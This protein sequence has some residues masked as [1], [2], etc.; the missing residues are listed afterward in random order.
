MRTKADIAWAVSIAII[1]SVVFSG[2]TIMAV[3]WQ[4]TIGDFAAECVDS[5][6]AMIDNNC[7][8]EGVDTPR[9]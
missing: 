9:Q 1:V 8:P 3:N 7:Y 5:G 4:N 2:I 6:G